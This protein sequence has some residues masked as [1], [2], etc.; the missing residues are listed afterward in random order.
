MYRSSLQAAHYDILMVTVRPWPLVA[1]VIMT[2]GKA[3]DPGD[4]SLEVPASQDGTLSSWGFIASAMPRRATV[5]YL[6]F[7]KMKPMLKCLKLAFLLLTKRGRFHFDCLWEN[8]STMILWSYSLV[9]SNLQ[10]STMVCFRGGLPGDWQIFTMVI[11]HVLFSVQLHW[12]IVLG[13]GFQ[14]FFYLSKLAFWLI[15]CCWNTLATCW[16]S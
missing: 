12:K 14:A 5:N 11:C 6:R 16:P 15:T 3:E 9:L 1:V 2:G 10:Y 8:I 13:V 4:N 7:R